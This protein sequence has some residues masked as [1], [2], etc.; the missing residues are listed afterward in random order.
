M[1]EPPE[2]RHQSTALP[3]LKSLHPSGLVHKAF[4]M[5]RG[6]KAGLDSISCLAGTL[7]WPVA[8][9]ADSHTPSGCLQV[10]DMEFLHPQGPWL[11]GLVQ[12]L[13]S[14]KQTRPYSERQGRQG[15]RWVTNQNRGAFRVSS[16]EGSGWRERAVGTGRPGKASL[17]LTVLGAGVCTRAVPGKQQGRALWV[18]GAWSVTPSRLR[19]PHLNTQEGV[20]WAVLGA[21]AQK[22]RRR[23]LPVPC[24]WQVSP[25]L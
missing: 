4:W 6:G 22:E 7:M 1:S 12:T 23:P 15:D 19:C 8:H 16:V 18:G 9:S 11:H 10:R 24:S 3:L 5:E 14:T 2:C 25:G 17:R 20:T 21:L 13:L